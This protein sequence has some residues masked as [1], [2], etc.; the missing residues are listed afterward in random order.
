MYLFIRDKIVIGRI[1]EC[2]E[3]VGISSIVLR[4]RKMK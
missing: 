4:E 2:N 1:D 3:S